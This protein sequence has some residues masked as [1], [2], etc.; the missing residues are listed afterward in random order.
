VLSDTQSNTSHLCVD[1]GESKKFQYVFSS[2]KYF[3]D[4]LDGKLVK[5]R[6]DDVAEQLHQMKLQLAS[7]NPS[8]RV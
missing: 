4:E 8:I 1:F 2:I 6:R 7:F 5:T 3:D